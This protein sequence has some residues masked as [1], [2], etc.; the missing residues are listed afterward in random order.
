MN[1]VITYT[2]H[3][4]EPA[5]LAAPGGD[6]NTEVSLDYVPGGVLRG[7]LVAKYLLEQGAGAADG[8]QFKTLFLSG[9]V[10]YLNAYPALSARSLPTPR[11]WAVRKDEGETIYDR[12]DPVQKRIVEEGLPKGVGGPFVTWNHDAP[13]AP[14]IDYEIAI[15]TSRNRKAGQALENDPDSALFRYQAL[16]RD[17]AFA[18]VILYDD[19]SQTDVE[20]LGAMLNG[21]D[22]LLLGGSHRAGYGLSALS[23]VVDTPDGRAEAAT[24]GVHTGDTRF[25]LYLTSDAIL[26]DPNTGRPTTDIAAFLP[27]E[28]GKIKIVESFATSGW[29][30]GFNG[31]WGLPLPQQWAC[32]MG[33]IWVIEPVS[34][35]TEDAV[36]ALAALE[37]RGIGQ[38]TT[39]G[40]GR[41]LLEPNWSDKPFALEKRSL[42]GVG[43]PQARRPIGSEEHAQL[44]GLLKQMNR[45]QRRSDLDRRMAVAVNGIARKGNVRG[46]LSPSQLARIRLRVR[47]DQTASDFSAFISYLNGTEKR[48]SAD[49]QFRKYRVDG[50]NFRQWLL[51]LA[52]D[53]GSIWDKFPAEEAQVLQFGSAAYDYRAELAHEYTIKFISSLCRQLAKLE[54]DQ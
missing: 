8:D 14:E 12:T 3:L 34:P 32:R 53:P 47:R 20:Q 24:G 1:G 7:A 22:T 54:A 51:D 4:Q 26:Y 19:V 52:R 10:R 28:V 6:P 48:K 25:R 37:R 39:E 30:G 23:D 43:V 36:K 44:D 41:F 46:H 13:V 5:L 27:G 2:I 50:R 29:V 11:A 45:R 9:R 33:S 42:S 15:H 40:F 21:A 17:Q 38:R 31:H 18:G 35:L 16:A 49:D